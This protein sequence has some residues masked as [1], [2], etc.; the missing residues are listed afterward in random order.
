MNWILD[1]LKEQSTWRGI[2]LLAT[3][4]GVKLEPDMAEGIIAL[5]LAL[6]GMINIIRKAPKQL[7][8]PIVR[9]AIALTEEER[10]RLHGKRGNPKNGR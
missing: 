9:K 10:R 4:L 6:V 2:I 7:P 1:R 3:G 5:G 8:E